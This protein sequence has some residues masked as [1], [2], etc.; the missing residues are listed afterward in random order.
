MIAKYT[1]SRF[2]MFAVA[3]VS[4]AALAAATTT[5]ARAATANVIDR[6]IAN[7]AQTIAISVHLQKTNAALFEQT[8]AAL[9][10]PLS[11]TY[12][13]WL[14]DADLMRFSPSKAEID[15]VTAALKKGGL[16]VVSIDKYGFSLEARGTLGN[17]ARV[18]N[19]EIHQFERDGASF[20]AN[21]RPALLGGNAG[22]FVTAVAG[23][24]SHTIRPQLT[25][26]LNPATHQPY[27]TRPLAQAF[28]AAGTNPF[29]TTTEILTASATNTL[30]DSGSSY[31]A[32]V[33]TGFG[34]NATSAT[35]SVPDY[36]PTDLQAAYGLPAVYK[37]GITGAGQTIV[38]LEGYGYPTAEADANAAA[39][40]AGLPA[41]TKSNFSVVYPIGKPSNPNIGV[42]AGWN[43]EI[44]LDIQ[45][46][47]AIAPDAKIIVAA[48][49]GQDDVSFL[50]CMN[51]V[52]KQK[53]GFV[54]S[55]SWEEDQ[56]LFAGPPEQEA[57]EDVLKVAAAQG[58][59]FQFSTGDSGDGGLN[60][61]IGAPGVPAVAPHATAV[62]GTAILNVPGKAT[63]FP[64]SWGDDDTPL[65][66]AGN[67]IT[68]AAG[69]AAFIGGGG[70]GESVYWPKPSWQSALPG[71]GRQTPDVSAL[72]DP[73]TGFPLVITAG[74]QQ[75][76]EQGWGGTSLASP[77]FTAFWAL[78]NEK[79][80]KSLGVAGIAVASL[81]TGL[82]DVTDP[83][84]FNSLTDKFETSSTAST[85]YTGKQLFSGVNPSNEPS[86][87]TAVWNATAFNLDGWYGFAFGLD[88]SLT[89][90]KGWDNATGFG[91]PDGLSFVNAAAAKSR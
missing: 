24:E 4:I 44:A 33:V 72:A 10:D 80:G 61:P 43:I 66:L 2:K 62:G 68:P 39:K 21:I 55:D 45:S 11:P 85:T 9:Y 20:R 69:N 60:T 86:F 88:S 23:I 36:A 51:K 82:T 54:V 73:Y 41:L 76:I 84:G 32:A 81:T 6:G 48:C 7:P 3:T 15:T 28:A 14:T 52:I 50:Q 34:Y 56:D 26:A 89:A 75:G 78:A 1:D 65:Q 77:I 90:G 17:V 71:K 79:A 91:T 30:T 29:G 19:T 37:S 16:T 42:E 22:L 8:L 83:A 57:F 31:P 67:V 53:L 58:I 38:L 87:I 49:N 59:S 27:A 18:F 13:Q 35:G 74:G 70:G 5:G 12:H 47:H 40:L 25:R 46:A 63:Q 64:A